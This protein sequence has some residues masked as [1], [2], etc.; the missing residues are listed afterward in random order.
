MAENRWRRPKFTARIDLLVVASLWFISLAMINPLGEFPLN[1]D[2]SFGLTVKH[3]LD[4]GDFR[5]IGWTSMPLITHVLWGSIFCIPMGFSFEALRFSTITIALVGILGSYCLIRELNRS[6]RVAAIIAFTIAFNPIY[7]ALSNTFMT[8]V[9]FTAIMIFAVLFFA[10]SLRSNSDFDLFVGSIL[11]VAATLN[12][13]LGLAVALAFGLSFVLKNGFAIRV[14]ARAIMPSLLCIGTLLAFGQWLTATGRLPVLYNAKSDALM[15]ALTDPKMLSDFA[16][17][18]FNALLY[19]GWFLL[20]ILI[21]IFG[22]IWFRLK[23]KAA[24][25]L[26]LLIFISI[27]TALLSF[28]LWLK[29]RHL[30]P[31]SGNIINTAGIGPLTLC[32][33]YLLHAFPHVAKLSATFW[34][35]ITGFSLLGGALLI[36]TCGIIGIRL[37]PESLPGK[38]NSRQTVP[39]FFL[40]SAGIYMIPILI[41]GF[42][43]R[44]LIP[45]I[46]LLAASVASL[47][48]KDYTQPQ[49]TKEK[50][51]SM[52]AWVLIGLF[53]IFAVC[54]TRD[55]LTWNRARWLILEDLL[56]SKHV[57][58]KDI[59]GGF[60][61]NGLHLYNSNYQRKPDKSWWWVYR[62][63]FVVAFGAIP[64]Y[65]VIRKI[66]YRKWMPPHYDSIMLLKKRKR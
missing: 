64:D 17:N 35:I 14:I 61:F 56:E 3:F 25:R 2:W 46:P 43:D 31:L 24:I 58:A 1:D 40:G 30:M 9:P 37:F 21:F 39:L 51:F 50:F 29:S 8:D 6:R 19:L 65:S 27:L 28:N 49:K 15:N 18:A 62:D 38:M 12:R 57:E 10:R 63:T 4:F 54:S 36:S 20:P 55:Y 41:N 26:K 60:E 5:P 59:D 34:L 45:I 42:F 13:Q 52:V 53:F 66:T 16:E 33:T 32:D 7:Y 22:D 47:S 11:I 44:Y 48:V 23:K